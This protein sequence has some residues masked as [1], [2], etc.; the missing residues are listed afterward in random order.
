MADETGSFKRLNF[1]RGFLTTEEDWNDGE[2]YHI[3]KRTLH[4][5]VL[6]APGVVPQFLGGLRVSQRGRGDLNVEVAAGYAVDGS[7]RDIFV[8]EPM[9]KT[10]NPKD[11]R[12][13]QTVYVVVSYTEEPTDFVAYKENIQFKGHKRIEEGAKIEVTA[14]EPDLEQEVELARIALDKGVKQIKDSLDPM[15]P[16]PN[17]IDLR[18][19][20][21][22]GVSGSFLSPMVRAELHELLTAKQQV[23]SHMAHVLGVGTALDVLHSVITLE[24]LLVSGYVD[25]RNIFQLMSTVLTLQKSVIEEVEKDHKDLSKKKEFGTFKWNVESVKMDRRY[26]MELL[27]DILTTQKNATEA[28]RSLFAQALRPRKK[29]RKAEVPSDVIWEKI[30][31]RSADFPKNLSVEGREFKR[32]DLLDIFDEKSEKS[33]H[34][35]ISDERDRYRSRQKLKYPDGTVIEDVGV[36][37]EGGHCSFEVMN[38]EPNRDV[39]VVMRIDYVRGDYECEVHVNGKKAPDLAVPGND[40]RFRWRNWPYVI[41]ADLVVEPILRVDLTPSKADRDVNFFTIWVYQPK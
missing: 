23:Y 28:L 35:L 36:H 26:T 10:I 40:M 21:V 15:N 22:A 27:V 18:Y 14:R 3:A 24:M 25:Y 11:Y 5:R 17:E 16:R 19:V 33:H 32:V 9:I 4:N 6:H 13:P 30:K 41:P 2:R 7:G 8:P 39:L 37:F 1:F 12:L 20:P 34:F 29:G 38:I 31:V